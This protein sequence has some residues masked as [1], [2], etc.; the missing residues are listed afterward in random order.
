MSGGVARNAGAV[1]AIERQLETNIAVSDLCQLCGALGAALYA[2]EQAQK[3]QA[4]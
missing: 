4:E 1:H 3:M 2:L